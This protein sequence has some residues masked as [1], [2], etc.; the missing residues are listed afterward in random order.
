VSQLSPAVPASGVLSDVIPG[1]KVRDAALVVTGA[2]LL[3]A[4]AQISIPLPFTPVPITGQT[5]AV[6]LLGSA[7]GV[8]RGLASMVLYLGV[9][10]AGVPVFSPDPKT[11]NPRTGEQMLHGASFGYIIG[12]AIAVVLVGWLAER[13]WDRRIGTSVL[14]MALGNLVVYTVG[15][16][17]LAGAAGL[18][19]SDALAKGLWPFL[20]GDGIKIALAAG[21][22]PAAWR[23]V[24][25]RQRD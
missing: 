5:F 1:A 20:V 14:Q 8:L 23:L 18:T 3:A 4:S 19:W 12:M 15:V 13:A 16:P 17:W 25:P 2:A 21:L 9:G 24:G 6:L 22:L 10:L 7:Y 11:G